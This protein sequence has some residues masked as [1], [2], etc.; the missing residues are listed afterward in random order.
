MRRVQALAA[1]LVVVVVVGGAAYAERE[2]GPEALGAGTGGSVRSGGWFCAHGGGEEWEVTLQLAN[3]GPATATVRIRTLGTQRPG[4]PEIVTVEPGATAAVPVDAA[5]RERASVVEWFDQWVAAGWVSHAGGDEG[6]VAA[7]P[8]APAA[9]TRWLLPDGTSEREEDD[10][11]LVIMN[12]F[13]RAAVFSVTL[14]S[15]R[16][17]PVRHSQLTDVELKPFRSRTIRLDRWVDGERTVASLVD[18]SV[19]RVAAAT[20]GVNELGGIR[21]STGYLG[22]PPEALVFPG[23][24]DAGRTD[25]VVMSTAEARVPLAGQLLGTEAEVEQPLAGLADSAP[26]SLSGRTF[27]ATTAGPSSLLLT[28]EGPGIAAARRTFGVE[29][30]QAST[31]GA[32]PAGAW[33]VLPAIFGEPAHPGLVLTNPGPVAVEITL[34][35]LAPATGSTTVTVPPR[36]TAPVPASFL[37]SSPGATILAVAGDGTFVPASASY[38][39]GREGFATYAVA[40]GVPIPEAWMPT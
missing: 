17:D 11:F 10:D 20:L 18:V 5:G 34:S 37:S 30:D 6:G 33:L 1:V 24:D 38:S 8:C 4:E 36:S 32:A 15:E 9:G 28:A 3:P 26:P 29:A 21:S 40:L 7:E 39:R 27:P 25:L 2:I 12:P 13:A 23:G 22:R 31:P 14:L 19:G 35:R 16:R